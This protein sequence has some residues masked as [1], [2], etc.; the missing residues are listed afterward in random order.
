MGM[1]GVD[2]KGPVVLLS[3]CGC[4]ERG[5][6]IRDSDEAGG[7]FGVVGVAV[8][9]VSFGE[10][11]KRSVVIMCYLICFGI[12]AESGGVSRTQL[13]SMSKHWK[14]VGGGNIKQ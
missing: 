4:T 2:V 13:E 11:V 10:G 3:F 5:V 7:S 8:W 9:V 1:M 12:D 6:S 14:I